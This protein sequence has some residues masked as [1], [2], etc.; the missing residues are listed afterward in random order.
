MH[1]LNFTLDEEAVQLLEQ[2]A[3]RYYHGNKS[4]TVRA[5]LES[6]A[7]HA[8]HDGWVITGYAPV[9]LA[10]EAACHT[11]GVSH[12]EGDVLFRPVFERGTSPKA[13]THIPSEVW[14]DCSGCVE[15]RFSA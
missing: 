2:L 5:A 3:A 15:A 7:A 9:Q 13:L 6:L 1:R 10:T 8:G 14:L 11:C 12:P 4:Q